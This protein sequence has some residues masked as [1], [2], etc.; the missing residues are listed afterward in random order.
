MFSKII[1]Y[2]ESVTLGNVS[3]V[4]KIQVRDFLEFPIGCL[5]ITNGGINEIFGRKD[6]KIVK[7]FISRIE[8]NELKA[9]IKDKLF[10]REYL[11][12]NF[13]VYRIAYRLIYTCASTPE[14]VAKIK[15]ELESIEKDLE[16]VLKEATRLQ[17]AAKREKQQIPKVETQVT[18][19]TEAKK[20]LTEFNATGKRK[21][22]V[23]KTTAPI[24]TP[25]L[26]KVLEESK[27]SNDV[28]QS[29][30]SVNEVKQLRGPIDFDKLYREQRDFGDDHYDIGLSFS[31]GED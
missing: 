7:E 10:K 12:I 17:S 3:V 24:V 25:E 31:I 20:L 18:S 21:H 11:G 1:S 14:N 22:S 13:Y 15:A 9:N 27:G 23:I 8:T 4:T 29:Q 5:H 16:Q 19:F 6:G 2:K 28:G 30:T 26:T